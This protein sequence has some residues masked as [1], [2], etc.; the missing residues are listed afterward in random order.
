MQKPV[1]NHYAPVAKSPQPATSNSR[2]LYTP[3]NGQNSNDSKTGFL[4]P[5]PPP[6]GGK[7][8]SIGSPVFGPQS[9]SLPAVVSPHKGPKK[10]FFEELPIPTKQKSV[11]S[12]L[13]NPYQIIETKSPSANHASLA[14]P[15]RKDSLGNPYISSPLA[16]H[17]NLAPPANTLHIPPTKC[18]CFFKY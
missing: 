10:N 3:V 14:P 7:P 16:P 9:P 12:S 2:S 6:I 13:K 17:R 18:L 4:A 11:S 15:P 8:P 1:I 5:P